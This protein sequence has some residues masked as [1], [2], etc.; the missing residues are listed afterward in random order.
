M[1]TIEMHRILSSSFIVSRFLFLLS[2]CRQAR[3]VNLD[4]GLS[5]F[6]RARFS[7]PLHFFLL[8][9]SFL[10]RQVRSS[11]SRWQARSEVHGSE[12][13]LMRSSRRDESKG[14]NWTFSLTRPASFHQPPH[15][16]L[17]ECSHWAVDSVMLFLRVYTT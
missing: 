9:F 12:R 8:R 14:M 3:F 1:F 13:M 4:F 15:R 5:T 17:V 10:L 16:L 7:T 2:S 6:K 11:N